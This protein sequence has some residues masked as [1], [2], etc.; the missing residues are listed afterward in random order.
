MSLANV[1]QAGDG[2]SA[3]IRRDAR[4]L[5]FA[6]LHVPGVHNLLNAL[7]AIVVTFHL[8]VGPEKAA[9][10]LESFR[11]VRRR[12]EILYD[13]SGIVLMD[14]FAHHPTAVRVTCEGVRARYPGR[15]L[16]A[17]FEP[18]SNTSRR[19]VFQSDYVSVFH[20]AD[21]I[22]VREPRGVDSIPPQERFSSAKLAQD[23]KKVG[24]N[25]HSFE[26]TDEIVAFLREDLHYGDVVLVMSNGSFDDLNAR[27][28][29]ALR[30]GWR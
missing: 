30:E 8:G 4:T 6:T 21:V 26:T 23:L 27:L 16:V 18:R 14:D 10:A 20:S 7:A 28:L 11:G 15:R 12:Q 22:L 17:V 9:A 2:V 19:S 5:A 13:E 24:K 29:A 3:E 1:A 25:A